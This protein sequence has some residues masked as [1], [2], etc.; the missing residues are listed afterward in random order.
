MRLCNSAS[1][2]LCCFS[3]VFITSTSL[4]HLYYWSFEI[5][6]TFAIEIR[7]IYNPWDRFIQLL[8]INCCSQ[9]LNI[10]HNQ[11]LFLYTSHIFG[12]IVCTPEYLKS[13]WLTLQVEESHFQIFW[14]TNWSPAL[15]LTLCLSHGIINWEMHILFYCFSQCLYGQWPLVTF[16]QSWPSENRFDSGSRDHSLEQS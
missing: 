6:S 4:Y 2:S 8:H 3:P 14:Y 1:Y 11:N 15:F 16:I 7:Y 5:N 13:D 9:L 10:Q 12:K